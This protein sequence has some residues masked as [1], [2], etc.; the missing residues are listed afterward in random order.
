MHYLFA[1]WWHHPSVPIAVIATVMVASWAM[2][3]SELLSPDPIQ[4]HTLFDWVKMT[5]G[6]LI[7]IAFFGLLP[8]GVILALI[9]GVSGHS[10][11]A[12][13]LP[14]VLDL[15]IVA[16]AVTGVGLYVVYLD[17]PDPMRQ[18]YQALA[19]PQR[20]TFWCV[21]L[22]GAAAFTAAGMWIILT[23]DGGLWAVIYA[24]SAI[25]FMTTPIGQG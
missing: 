25:V 13:S 4:L 16:G 3:L 23:Q 9:T 19:L 21:A 12:D 18:K 1:Q 10:M 11:D 20:R 22:I 8:A 14:W 6:A 7:R 5:A 17:G 15:L 2:W 24:T